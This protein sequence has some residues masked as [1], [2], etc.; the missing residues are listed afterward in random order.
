MFGKPDFE[1]PL[2]A[3]NP[4]AALFVPLTFIIWQKHNQTYISYWDPMTDIQP[5]L[6]FKSAASIA[7]LK[8]TSSL[9]DYI[10][11]QAGKK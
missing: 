2:I 4:Q 7:D 3:E 6:N 5:L 9:L 1:Y 8:H 11:H 10:A